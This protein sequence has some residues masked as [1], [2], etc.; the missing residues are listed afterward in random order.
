MMTC[1]VLCRP[2]LSF[3]RCI[4]PAVVFSDGRPDGHSFAR[5]PILFTCAHVHVEDEQLHRDIF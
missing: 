1:T 3:Y 4:A 5:L 2:T